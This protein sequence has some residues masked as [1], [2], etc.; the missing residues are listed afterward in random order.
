MKFAKVML[1]VTMLL[2]SVVGRAAEADPAAHLKAVQGL[3]AAMQTEKLMRSI[4]GTSGFASEALRAKAF[5]KLATVKPS[6]IHERL[7]R[8]T[9]R[10]ISQSTAVEMT[11]YY[12]LA[13]GRAVLWQ[14]YNSRPGF[15]KN[16]APTPTPNERKFMS[17]PEFI[18]AK[19]ELDAAEPAIRHEGFLLMQAIYQ[20]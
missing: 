13:H 6:D 14:T 5:A 10:F 20:G 2:T 1:L 8:Q 4:T 3:M 7:G 12:N 16:D 9:Q 19:K 18:K 15:A 11:A 17:R